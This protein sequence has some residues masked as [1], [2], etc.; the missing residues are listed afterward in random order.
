[1]GTASYFDYPTGAD[2]ET[3]CSTPGTT[4]NTANC[5]MVAGD[6]TRVGSYMGS[7]VRTAPSTR[8]ETPS[9]PWPVL[10]ALNAQFFA[11]GYAAL[12]DMSVEHRP[13]PGTGTGE[14]RGDD[15]GRRAPVSAKTDG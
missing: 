7:A 13:R 5:G 14:S 11:V 12:T 8:A 1:M 9:N 3:V 2:A 4:P 15:V 10:Q 6:F